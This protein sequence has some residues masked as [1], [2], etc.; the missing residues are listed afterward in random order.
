MLLKQSNFH[1]IRIV[2]FIINALHK[3][4]RNIMYF[5]VKIK[6]KAETAIKMWASLHILHDFE[7][8]EMMRW[9]RRKLSLGPA[10]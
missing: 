6:I 2:L 8:A 1:G 10:D 9:R 5:K 4:K 7:G 3:K